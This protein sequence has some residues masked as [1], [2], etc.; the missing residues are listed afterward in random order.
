MVLETVKKIA[1]AVEKRPKE[2]EAA[3]KT[4][5]KVVGWLEYNIP[6]EVIHALGLIPIRLGTGGSDRITELGSRYIS[7][8]NC[9]FCRQTVG[10]FAEKKDPYIL[11]SDLVAF[12]GTCLQLYRVAEL[13]KYYFK[14]NT[15]VLGVPKN[16]Y[17]PEGKEYFV[18]ELEWFT[19]ELETFAGHKL[20]KKKL[21][22]SIKLYDNI[23]K[24]TQELYKYQAVD[25]KPPITWREVYD[26]IQAGYYLDRE[27]YLGYL[28][29]LLAELK[30]KHGKA[31]IGNKSGDTRIFLSGSLIPPEDRKLI[32]IIEDVHGRIVVDDLWSGLT[33]SHGLTIKEP[34][35]KGIAEAY[36]DRIPP[37]AALP[38]LD[39]KTDR[40]LKNLSQLYKEYKA[41]GIIYHSLR[42]CD[43]FTFKA[44][45]LKEILK[46]DSIPFLEIHTEYS[47][48]DVEAIRTRV[49]TFVET[50]PK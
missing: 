27:Q 10:S 5:K 28:K 50:I 14:V 1:D 37:H 7:S 29:E 2:L 9:V 41:Q 36:L 3:R 16:F 40:R 8:K 11:N 43:P 12:D 22:S 24:S 31:V 44:S 15:L 6:E 26:V 48:S 39:L 19:S 20:D 32:G 38:Y 13:V 35:L 46:K 42:F 17:L 18:K 30:T 25:G 33:P 49:E 45:E 4:G 34:T 23:R 47:G 21:A